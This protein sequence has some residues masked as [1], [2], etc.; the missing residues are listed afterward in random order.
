MTAAAG[1]LANMEVHLLLSGP[2]QERPTANLMLDYLFGAFV[3]HTNSFENA[4]VEEESKQLELDLT[5]KGKKVYR[6]PMGGST[7]IGAMGYIKAFAEIMDF[8]STKNITFSKIFLASGS[9]GTQAGL[10]MGKM[11]YQ[12]KGDIVGISVG[13]S[14]KELKNVIANIVEGTCELLNTE[15]KIPEIIVDDNFIGEG[16][17]RSTKG[18]EKAIIEFANLEGI[19]LDKVY[20]GKAAAGMLNYLSQGKIKP[21]ENI[22]FI[23]TGGNIE[24]FE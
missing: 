13:R 4:V 2:M 24:L 12:R 16:Y 5:K 1:K 3:H 23:H 6:M 8:C 22:L 10:V 17:G 18:G 20:T 11:L 14:E 15:K 9:G 21:S 7:P 19:L